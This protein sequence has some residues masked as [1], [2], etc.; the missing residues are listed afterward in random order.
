MPL[1]E[2]FRGLTLEVAR[3]DAADTLTL[4]AELDMVHQDVT[5]PAKRAK[6][7]SKLPSLGGLLGGWARRKKNRRSR[8]RP[9]KNFPPRR[10]WKRSNAKWV[11][12]GLVCPSGARCGTIVAWQP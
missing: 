2:W 7:A 11:A 12:G 6:A 3:V 10:R 5:P 9:T 4:H 1:M 8:N